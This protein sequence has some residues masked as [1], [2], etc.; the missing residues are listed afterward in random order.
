MV[1][2]D[3]FK[4]SLGTSGIESRIEQKVN[5]LEKEKTLL[6]INHALKLMNETR[7]NILKLLKSN[8]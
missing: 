1:H 7:K 5:F 8:Q 3:S 2:I 6:L 4:E